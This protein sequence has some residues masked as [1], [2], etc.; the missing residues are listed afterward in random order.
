[1]AYFP[2]FGNFFYWEKCLFI[3]LLYG[4]MRSM[5]KIAVILTSA[6][7]ARNMRIPELARRSGVSKSSVYRVLSDECTPSWDL[8]VNLIRSLGG[9]VSVVFPEAPTGDG[10]P[11]AQ[12]GD[13]SP[14]ALTGG[15]SGTPRTFR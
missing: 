10:S 8:A 11:E 6:L 2:V 14:K 4:K 9:T 5:E 12:T 15:S 13:S 1:M 3:F 7:K